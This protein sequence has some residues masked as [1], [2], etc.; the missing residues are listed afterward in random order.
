MQDHRLIV[1]GEDMHLNDYPH[2]SKN[3]GN[4]TYERMLLSDPDTGMSIKMIL[5]P[6]GNVTPMHDHHCAHGLY[7]LRGTLYTDSG[8][9]GPGSFIW[10]R[11]GEQMVHGG[12]DEDVQCLFITNKA[13]DIH[14]IR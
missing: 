13:F 11:E 14:Y 7:V 1:R 12:K 2:V 6:K 3:T 10:F 5:Y 4:L 9:Y 8:E